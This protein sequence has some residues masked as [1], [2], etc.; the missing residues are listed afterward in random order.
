MVA[1]TP[2]SSWD[3]PIGIPVFTA[4][5]Q[6]L[7]K[8]T[9]ADINGLIIEDGFL[10]FRRVYRAKLSDVERYEDGALSLKLTMD[11]VARQ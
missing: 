1:R 11:Q 10:F 8:V 6:R 5:G 2:D 9:E 7:G 3:I 4:D